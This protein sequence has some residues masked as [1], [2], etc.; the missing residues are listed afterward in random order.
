M[1]KITAPDG[2][3]ISQFS[4]GCMQ[5]GDKA[6]KQAARAMYNACRNAG[7]NFFDTAHVYT[8]GV[9]E[10]WLGE[11]IADE[12]DK[13]VVATK[14]NYKRGNAP[15]S[16]EESLEESRGRLRLDRIDLYYLHRWDDATPLEKSFEALAKAKRAGHIAQI[17]VS[18]FAA[19][20]VMKAQEAAAAFDLRIDV[21]QPMYNLVKRQAEVELL[22]M[23]NAENIA[24]VPYSPLGG[25]LLTG[26]YRG[27]SGEGR[28]T[29]DKMYAVRYGPEW[30]HNAAADLAY[31]ANTL[32]VDPA[33]LAV[34][35]A[36]RHPGVAA[37][38]ISARNVEQL[39][40]SL[41]AMDFEMDEE[42]YQRISGL[43]PTPPPA[44]DRL[45]EA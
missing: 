19:W 11:F 45:E 27:S 9:S 18:N 25:G 42:L 4:F 1:S 28:I 37:P 43:S 38:I 36:A 12:R 21:I 35:W 20:Q 17:G 7:I 10:T 33:T 3:P 34:A 2:T 22:P 32:R 8:D 6:D 44:T 26:K 5:F 13:I 15:D 31:L 24:V 23:S 40:P 41:A 39:N 16:I 30:M 14:A 29:G